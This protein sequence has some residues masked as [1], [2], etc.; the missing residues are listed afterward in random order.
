[1]EKIL[2]SNAFNQTEYLRTMAKLGHNTFALRV[3]NENEIC[4]FVL[5]RKGIFPQGRFVSSKEENYIFYYLS[6]QQYN[7][8]KNIKNAIDSYRDCVIGD[9][10][11]SLDNNLNDDFPEK[12]LLIKNLYK[13]YSEYKK[14]HQLY[15][16]YDLIHFILN[17]N[18]KIDIEVDYYEEYA[19][20]ELFLHMLN[21]VFAKVNKISLLDTFPKKE[22]EIHFMKA[23]GKPCEADYVLSTIIKKN[24]RLDECQIVLVN[25]SDTVD[26]Y[27]LM[28]IYNIPYA[29]SIGFPV[30]NT[31]AGKLL[32]YLFRLEDLH[33]AVDGYK[34]LFNCSVFNADEFKDL[35]IKDGYDRDYT[36]FIKYA[37]WLRVDYNSEPSDIHDELYKEEISK[38]L[39]ILQKAIHE[40]RASFISHFLRNPEPIDLMVIEEIKRIEE[41]SKY[42]I[43]IVEILKEFLYSTINKRISD[44]SSLHV[45]SLNTA[46]ASLRKHNFI[47]GLD[48][49]F[50]GGPKENYLI[51]DEEYLKTGSDIYTSIEVIKQKERLLRIFVSST[52]DLYISYPYF[53]IGELEDNNPSSIIFDLYEGDISSMPKYGYNDITLSENKDVYKACI[54]NKKSSVKAPI[55]NIQYDPCILLDKEYQPS[56]FHA[57]FETENRLAFL[58]SNIYGLNIDEEDDPFVVMSPSDKG[59]L[60]HRVMER[61]DKNK[62]TFKVFKEKADAEFEKFILQKPP[63]IPSSKQKAKEDYDRLIEALYKM[64]PKNK[65]IASEIFVRNEIKG[66][67]F[68]G[69]FDRL[70]K[71]EMGKYIL[72]DYKTGRNISHKDEDTVSC[73]QGLIYAYLI[74]HIDDDRYK[75]LQGIKIDRI[76]FRYPEHEK[77]IKIT[78]NDVHKQELFDKI[79]EFKQA[80][81]NADLVSH[82]PDK[83]SYVD[84]YEHLVSLMK[85]VRNNG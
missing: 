48:S 84:K 71:D 33:F 34:Q 74:E 44:C 5:M 64:N 3:M 54:N 18:I 39:H 23:Y 24:Y 68:K 73:I 19:I 32:G 83:D 56:F 78:Y 59:T 76:E 6:G 30:L 72:V 8:A 62:T 26:I 42:G 45:T 14:E 77:S 52:E 81:L 28:D 12:K 85:E 41:A 13:Q 75:W 11:Q 35:L 17:E 9:V 20:S 69:F 2:F 40:G 27:R 82:N 49:D 63:L 22:K 38:S 57:F 15:D 51:F 80:I 60:I 37:G 29:S 53:E 79:E 55:S 65:H 58:L 16:K 4:S 70:E 7:D 1:M 61:F 67:K 21:K 25:N 47:I 66:I 46:F 36:D 31:N 10:Y 50:P 43:N